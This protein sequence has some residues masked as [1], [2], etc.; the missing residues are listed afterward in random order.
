MAT[1]TTTDRFVNDVNSL[2][3]SKRRGQALDANLKDVPGRTNLPQ[4]IGRS[5]LRE[6]T[7]GQA[8]NGI[9]SPLTEPDFSTRTYYATVGELTSTDGL[10]VVELQGLHTIDLEDFYGKE[11]QFVLDDPY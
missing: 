2:V 1:T 10:I 9:A 8:A 5:R 4:Q 7:G 6:S 3:E 11:V